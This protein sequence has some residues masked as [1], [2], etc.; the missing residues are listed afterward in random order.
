MNA[1]VP[2]IFFIYVFIVTWWILLHYK[3]IKEF[4][5][6]MIMCNAFISIT[7]AIF[8]FVGVATI[9]HI[10]HKN[11]NYEQLIDDILY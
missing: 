4:S 11:E 1:I 5:S 6:T 9:Y 8:V 3:T 2:Y 10:E 7:I